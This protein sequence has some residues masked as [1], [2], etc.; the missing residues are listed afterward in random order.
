MVDDVIMVV[1]V[2][3]VGG[4]DRRCVPLTVKN[5]RLA[6]EHEHWL[7]KEANRIDASRIN[8][9]VNVLIRMVLI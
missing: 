8:W 3:G 9:L 6:D 2:G 1:V 4:K 7:G 5:E